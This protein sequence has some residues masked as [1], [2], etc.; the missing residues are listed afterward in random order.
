MFLNA[1]HLSI[2]INDKFL[3]DVLCIRF[4][5]LRFRCPLARFRT[6]LTVSNLLADQDHD[7]AWS[8]SRPLSFITGR[9]GDHGPNRTSDCGR[10]QRL[11]LS[12]SLVQRQRRSGELRKLRALNKRQTQDDGTR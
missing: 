6:A 11:A 9:Q 10:H 1:Y 2:I 4:R 5:R 12:A 3:R 8:G 7:P